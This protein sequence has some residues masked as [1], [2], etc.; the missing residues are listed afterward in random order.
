M[1]GKPS[2]QRDDVVILILQ[3]ERPIRCTVKLEFDV[4]SKLGVVD[5]IIRSESLMLTHTRA[6]D[7]LWD[8]WGR[9]RVFV[10]VAAV[11]FALEWGRILMKVLERDAR[12]KGLRRK[13]AK[14]YGQRVIA[15]RRN[16]GHGFRDR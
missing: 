13:E 11:Q 6:G 10:E 4:L 16:F 12:G 3:F 9:E 15:E 7:R 2:N 5:G 14:L 8:V 1:W